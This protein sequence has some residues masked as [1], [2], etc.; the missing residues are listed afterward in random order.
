MSYADV[1]ALMKETLNNYANPF[2]KNNNQLTQSVA[3]SKLHR[4]SIKQIAADKH[5]R[6]KAVA[7]ALSS[8]AN[9]M[10]ALG[11]TDN[12]QVDIPYVIAIFIARLKL[13]YGLPFNYLVPDVR[14]LPPE[15]LKFFYMDSGWLDALVE[16]ALAIGTSTSGESSVNQALS[17]VVHP[18]M[19]IKAATVRKSLLG[20]QAAPGDDN[21]T[22]IANVTGF[23]LRSQVVTGWPGLEVHGFDSSQNALDLLRL[24]QVGPGVLLCI[25]NG[26]VSQVKIQMH[27][28]AL[29]FGVDENLQDPTA[30][31]TKSFRYITAV[32]SNQPGAQVPVAAVPPIT[33][34]NYYRTGS[35]TVLQMDSLASA[36]QS[37]LSQNNI[38][39]GKFTSAEFALEMIE[40]VQEVVYQF[41]PTKG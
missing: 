16:G 15:S 5:G 33:L 2:G 17:Q 25:F 24:D 18:A 4:R 32:G 40:G 31:F 11:T 38:Y 23:L 3:T 34:T 27:P 36:I 9:V 29:H 20:V 7:Q 26:I 41:S 1:V 21:I 8:P 10:Q 28:E 30:P 6:R 12:Q 35:T 37:T 19:N 39:S 14:M 13:L 22:P